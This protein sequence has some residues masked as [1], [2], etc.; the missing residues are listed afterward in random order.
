[1]GCI[2]VVSMYTHAVMEQGAWVFIKGVF[3]KSCSI[4]FFQRRSLRWHDAK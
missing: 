4:V 3:K 2:G 1:M